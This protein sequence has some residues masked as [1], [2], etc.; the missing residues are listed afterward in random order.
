MENA[1]TGESRSLLEKDIEEVNQA[2]K[3]QKCDPGPA[4]NF[5]PSFGL[6]LWR[7]KCTGN[8]F[9]INDGKYGRCK[10]GEDGSEFQE[11][12][13]IFRKENNDHNSSNCQHHNPK[14]IKSTSEHL[15]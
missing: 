14:E 4:E 8:H 12:T 6:I 1:Y 9:V 15:Q 10:E 11:R 2:E 7:H 13:H 3:Y 5:K